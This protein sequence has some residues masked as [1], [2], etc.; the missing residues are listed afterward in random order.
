MQR[1]LEMF[2]DPPGIGTLLRTI[3]KVSVPQLHQG[4]ESKRNMLLHRGPVLTHT[5]LGK[6]LGLRSTPEGD[7]RKDLS[8]IILA[9]A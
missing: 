3:L 8:K 4:M 7:M 1:A 9:L 6:S 2:L 5:E